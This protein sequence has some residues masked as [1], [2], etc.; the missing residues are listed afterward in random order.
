MNDGGTSMSTTEYEERDGKLLE[1]SRTAS[2]VRKRE[3]TSERT[4][5][6][7]F[8]GVKRKPVEHSTGDLFQKRN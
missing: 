2:L 8:T 4:L 7:I 5:G 3:D 1:K 6:E